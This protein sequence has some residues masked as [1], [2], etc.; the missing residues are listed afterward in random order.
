MQRRSHTPDDAPNFD[1]DHHDM[2]SASAGGMFAIA[3][4]DVGRYRPT[5]LARLGTDVKS[6]FGNCEIQF[7]GIYGR[8]QSDFHDRR[9]IHCNLA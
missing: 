4:A 7:G 8:S 2:R 9:A 3:S 6:P 1:V 5:S